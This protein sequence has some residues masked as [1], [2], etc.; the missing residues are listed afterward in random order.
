M[1]PHPVFEPGT[2]L[3]PALAATARSGSG[4][5]ARA[6]TAGFAARLSDEVL[7]GP[8]VRY[9]EQFGPVRQQIEG[10]DAVPPYES[11]P[12]LAMLCARVQSLVRA[13]GEGI[14]GLR[15]WRVNEAGVVV[16]RDG[17]IGITS[18]RDGLWY[19]RLVAVVTVSGRAE[20]TI[21]SDRSG[22]PL[23]RYPCEPGSL[24]LLRAPGL[25]SRRD[26][27]PFHAVG[28]PLSGGRCAI[29]LRMA[30]GPRRPVP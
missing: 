3:A 18:H 29:A 17:S 30:V 7:D 5:V 9:R 8:L 28:T 25:A 4:F 24:V 26:G 6:V 2:D 22:T 15:T 1:H 11:L 19:R 23:A 13:H 27:R 10:F 20:L 12:G 21:C 16:Y 14:R